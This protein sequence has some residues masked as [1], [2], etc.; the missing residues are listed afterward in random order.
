MSEEEVAIDLLSAGQEAE[1]LPTT[2]PE[3]IFMLIL[4]LV[5]GAMSFVFKY[6]KS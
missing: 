3:H 5:F 2:G 6:R 4:A 1:T